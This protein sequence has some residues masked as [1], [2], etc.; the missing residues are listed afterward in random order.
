MTFIQAAASF[1]EREDKDL[2]AD[3]AVP[4]RHIVIDLLRKAAPLVGLRAPVI[5]TLDAMLSCLPP[6]R[7]HHT[8][9]ASNAT[10]AFRRNGISDRT[11]RRHA[12][13][14]QEAGLL[15]RHDSPNKKRFKRNNR[16]DGKALLFGFDLSPLFARIAQI[17]G[18]AAETART[19]EQIGYLR[20]KIRAAAND[21]LRNDADNPAAINALRDLRRKLSR[22]DCEVLLESLTVSAISA[23]HAMT[24]SPVETMKMAANGGQ[25]VRLHHN[26]NKENR[27][28][29]KSVSEKPLSV[30]ELINACPE[31]A[32]FAFEKII[33]HHDIV[34]HAQRL[35]PMIGISP[36]NYHAA[37][38]RLG[39]MGTAITIWAMMQ[40]H[41]RISR[42]GAYFRAITQGRKSMGFDP[43]QLV[44]R[45]A[46]SQ[47]IDELSADNLAGRG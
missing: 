20:T 30:A 14:L 13:L 1:R 12:A 26:S 15:T 10:L 4:E 44:R 43:T 37:E 17:A 18:L 39:S 5:A 9:F 23:E 38:N 6:K 32:Q 25:N 27:S 41:G 42:A 35:A 11:I 3:N 24:T 34:A 28:E 7:S 40:F 19:A 29:N 21:L 45:L 36:E 2:S 8:V 46:A 33:T 22:N 47:Q 16:T 31:A